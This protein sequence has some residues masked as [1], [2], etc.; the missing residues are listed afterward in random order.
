MKTRIISG[1]VMGIIVAAVLA[2]GLVLNPYI[3][4]VAIAALS[5]GAIYELLH[6]AAGIK[7]KASLI[8]ACS[9][10][11]LF[12][13]VADKWVKDGIHSS[14]KHDCK[15]LVLDS[16]ND[17]ALSFEDY[18]S[19]G[20]TTLIV[21]Y[22]IFAVFMILKNNKDFALGQI[23]ALF[24]FPL[25]YAFAFS[26]LGGVINQIGGIYYLLL[27]LNFSSVCDMGA[28]FTGVTMGKHKLCPK[29]S[30]KKTVEGAVGGI[31]SSIIVTLI[32]TLCFGKSVILPLALTIP[33]CI[34]G[35]AGDLFA[36]AIKRAVGIKDY[37]N[38]IP[39]HGGILDR[40]DSIL[41]IV[42]LMYLMI[43]F[44]VL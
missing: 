42:P 14:I 34:L 20:I 35:M 17:V 9:F 32:I 37:G 23:A 30:P 24:G 18:W 4:T 21:L 40:V 29:L 1:I 31:L 7:C 28:Y 38:L 10:S 6:T 36:S 33:L 27:L 15:T 5:A 2:A 25:A 8:G 41:M 19:L 3:I 39:G 22:F 12:V 43:S 16:A 11:A 13:I 44:G 26:C